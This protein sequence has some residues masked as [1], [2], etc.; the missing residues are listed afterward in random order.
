MIDNGI[1]L[2]FT[3]VII[4][5]IPVVGTLIVGMGAYAFHQTVQNF[6][7]KLD[8]L[9]STLAVLNANVARL[10]DDLVQARIDIARLQAEQAR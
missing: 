10:N 8:T 2:R 1:G 9:T 7:D 3:R 6:T 5:S 4:L